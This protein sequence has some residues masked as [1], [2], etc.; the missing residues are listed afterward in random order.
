[1]RRVAGCIGAGSGAGKKKPEPVK[2]GPASQ[3]WWWVQYSIQWATHQPGVLPAEAGG[4]DLFGDAAAPG[5]R[6]LQHG[7]LPERIIST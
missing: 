7:H 1:M 4:E 6:L 5:L 3:H 2:Y